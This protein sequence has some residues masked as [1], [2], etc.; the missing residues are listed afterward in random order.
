MKLCEVNKVT[1]LGDW[2]RQKAKSGDRLYGHDGYTSLLQSLMQARAEGKYDVPVSNTPPKFKPKN[3]YTA[4]FASTVSRYAQMRVLEQK[5]DLRAMFGEDIVTPHGGFSRFTEDLGTYVISIGYG[6]IGW[7]FINNAKAQGVEATDDM[8][9]GA[10]R[11][12]V[13]M[14][15]VAIAE[16]FGVAAEKITVSDTLV[17]IVMAKDFAGVAPKP[18]IST[19]I[20]RVFKE[21]NMGGVRFPWVNKLQNGYGVKIEAVELLSPEEFVEFSKAVKSTFG[22][23]FLKVKH[24]GEISSVG[25]RPV[26]K[27]L[28][29]YRFYFTNE[30]KDKYTLK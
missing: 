17:T 18:S 20:A 12:V 7:S 8:K 3:K 25:H 5:P 28:T 1:D 22:D 6:S 11:A 9:R 26:G 21:F 24:D 2:K 14:I 16:F 10:V 15:A 19:A 27:G 30:L 4:A 23:I 13:R 29:N